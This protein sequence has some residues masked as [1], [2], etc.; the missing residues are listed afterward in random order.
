MK[1]P[2]PAPTHGVPDSFR[3][4][5]GRHVTAVL[6]G[7]DRLR[8]RTT[9]RLLHVPRGMAAHL[10]ACHV[11][12]QDFA[13]HAGATTERIRAATL[14]AA[15]AAGWPVHHLTSPKILPEDL[16][17]RI[18]R[19]DG[20]TDGLITLLTATESCL[21]YSVRGARGAADQTTP[22]GPAA[23]PLPASV[24][25]LPARRPRRRPPPS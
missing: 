15:R 6:A 2:T 12:L 23:A 14:A 10:N 8:F 19:T 7:F 20:I 22:A 13:T 11:L 4:Q 18:A 21:S 25:L 16:A 9:R 3:N 17:R 1:N 24:S 5:F